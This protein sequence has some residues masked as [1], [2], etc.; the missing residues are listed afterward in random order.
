MSNYQ[1]QF[2]TEFYQHPRWYALSVKPQHEKRVATRLRYR[3]WEEFLPLHRSQRFWSDRIKKLDL[4]LFPG[5]V[6]C[7]FSLENHRSVLEIPSVTSIIGF[8]NIPTP[9]S[10]KEIFDLKNLVASGFPLEP[11][12]FLKVGQKIRIERGSLKGLEG[13][14]LQVRDSW[15]V[16][17]SI[18]LL[19][20][21]IA[22]EID[23]A[24]VSAIPNSGVPS[25]TRYH[26]LQ[27]SYGNVVS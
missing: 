26:R 12:P 2:S 23:A 13:I 1:S 11:W 8:G 27:H 7:R 3:G 20:R 6:F 21:S 5:Y 16:V 18:F 4:P 17:V 9:V 14:L 19:Q 22:V 15:R 24:F 25:E 10:D